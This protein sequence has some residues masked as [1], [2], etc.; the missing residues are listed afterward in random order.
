M[1]RFLQVVLA[2]GLLS[3]ILGIVVAFTGKQLIFSTQGFWRGAM[4]CW[5]LVVATR[6]TYLDK[7]AE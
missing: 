4:A 5:L 6:L 1:K 3:L 7:K 2:L